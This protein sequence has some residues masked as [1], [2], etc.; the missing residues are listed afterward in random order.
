MSKEI[1]K[2]VMSGLLAGALLTG[3]LGMSVC[4]IRR[5]VIDN[6][7]TSISDNID[8]LNVETPTLTIGHGSRDEAVYIGFSIGLDGYY[9]I[10]DNMDKIDGWELYEKLEDGY[11]LVG[12]SE[13]YSIDVTMDV[14]Q[15]NT[16]VARTFVLNKEGHKVYSGFSNEY[17]VTKSN[18]SRVN[19]KLLD[20][21][22]NEYIEDARLVLKDINGV[23]IAEFTT[24]DADF[25]IDGLS[26]G[27]YTLTQLSSSNGYHL[28]V[29]SINFDVKGSDVDIVMY[30]T[31]MTE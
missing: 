22:T 15:A 25:Y 14:G 16:Y 19:I 12:T 7:T 27:I 9:A 29:E 28:N 5:E 6:S 26:D 3:A 17:K 23:V 11:K 31:K 10:K 30:N 18:K 13:K 4:T 21:D 24:I 1:K 2:R 20:K 8:D